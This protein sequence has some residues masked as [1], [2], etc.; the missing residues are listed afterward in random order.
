MENIQEKI[1]KS[2]I[3]YV[4]ENNKQ[5]KSVASF[6]ETVGESEKTFY[7]HYGSF[8]NLEASIWR[9]LIEDT[10]EKMEAEEVY[11]SYSVR[12]KALSFYFTLIETLKE[13]RSF[14]KYCFKKR[15]RELKPTPSFLTEFKDRFYNF[16]H[17][18]LNEGMDT[19]E[20][21]SRP[22][23][24][25]RYADGLWIQVMFILN[26]W[27]NDRSAGFETTDAAIEKAVNVTFDF[28]GRTPIDSTIDFV[29]FVWQNRS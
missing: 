5:P 7:D 22:F 1:E 21:I 18:I 27:V 4:S 9:S 29:K 8:N 3:V 15:K 20:V 23:I 28:Y 14:V 11:A 26:F 25:D 6:M 12:E 16:A 17:E 2:Y 13:K 10:I 24:S 19:E